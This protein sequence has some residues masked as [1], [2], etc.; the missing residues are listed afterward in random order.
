MYIHGDHGTRSFSQVATTNCETLRVHRIKS[1]YENCYDRCWLRAK[2]WHAVQADASQ[3]YLVDYVPLTAQPP[4]L[5]RLLKSPV[6]ELLPD[7]QFTRRFRLSGNAC[8]SMS[9]R[10]S[11]PQAHRQSFLEMSQIE[12]DCQECKYIRT[13]KLLH[14]VWNFSTILKFNHPAS[15]LPQ[16]VYFL[17][18]K[19][20]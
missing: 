9:T 18:I 10:N 19:R 7:G 20:P 14:L 3:R 5:G 6:C 15:L 11:Y 4:C 8:V 13:C 17:L 16:S 1:H 2:G 12:G